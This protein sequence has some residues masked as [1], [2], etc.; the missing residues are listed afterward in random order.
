MVCPHFSSFHAFW[1][2]SI[3][4][5]FPFVQQ[6]N[7]KKF[8]YFFNGL[9]PIFYY[10][11]FILYTHFCCCCCCCWKMCST[12]VVQMRSTD[13]S[14]PI[15][16]DFHNFE[17]KYWNFNIQVVKI[18]NLFPEF[19]TYFSQNLNI[20]VEMLQL[21]RDIILFILNGFKIGLHFI[22]FIF[23]NFS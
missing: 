14:L 20:E 7:S 10:Y 1:I 2:K 23:C 13:F 3:D 9:A 15:L 12:F 11:T 17:L 22:L 21:K 18:V 8:E 6:K 4:I 19:K 16:Y 5:V